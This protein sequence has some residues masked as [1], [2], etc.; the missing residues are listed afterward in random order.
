[1]QILVPIT[2]RSRFFPPEEHFFPK[3][4]IEVAGR[5]M[6]ERVVGRLRRDVP[7]ARFTFVIDR[8]EASSFSLDRILRFAAGKDTRVVERPGPTAGALCSCLLAVDALEADEPLLIANS[9]QIVDDDVGVHLARFQAAGVAAGVVT[10]DSV[11]P[12]WSY[13][14]PAGPDRVAQT[15]EKRVVSRHAIAGLYWFREAASFVRGARRT[16]LDDAHV[17]GT[18]YTSSTLNQVILEGGEVA[19]SSIRASDYHNF[20]EPARIAQFERTALAARL[21]T[22]DARPSDVRV[23]VPAAGEGSRFAREGWRKPKPFIDV[24]GRPMLARVIDNVRPAGAEAIVLARTQHMEA[25]PA[26]TGELRAAGVDFLALDKL[27]EGTACTVL[28]ARPR[29]DDDAPMMVANSDQLVDFEVTEFVRDCLDRN[30]D[31]S[32]LVFRDAARDPKW[33]F[34]R[35]NDEGLVVEVAEKKPISDLATVGIYLFR[36]GRDFVGAAADM[37]AANDRVNGEFYTCPVYNYMIASGAR[38]GIY[39][40]P[41]EAMHG[42]G[43]PDDLNAY[44]AARNAPPSTDGPNGSGND[45]P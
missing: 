31:G 14:L 26:L 32:I 23:V 5:P 36:R 7:D 16:L 39:E 10:F 34:A 37:I 28:S 35:L 9:D 33:S 6:I 40:V 44:L 21:R 18:F 13:V 19:F 15:H 11:H 42:I 3:P 41:A 17:D 30:L 25:E 1:M 27:T 22:G 29:F 12:R 38:I 24:E 43:T 20:H 4:L 2:A 8:D 45:A